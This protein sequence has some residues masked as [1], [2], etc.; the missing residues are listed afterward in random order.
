MNFMYFYRDLYSV[1]QKAFML[2]H[3]G[4]KI[5]SSLQQRQQQS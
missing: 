3:S 5:I 4:Y 2:L 1:K